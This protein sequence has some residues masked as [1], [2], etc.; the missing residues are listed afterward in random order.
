MSPTFRNGNLLAQ[1]NLTTLSKMLKETSESNDA[2]AASGDAVPTNV[3]TGNWKPQLHFIWDILFDVYFPE[4]ASTAAGDHDLL[5]KSLPTADRASF[6]DFW[7]VVV[8]EGLFN[9]TSTPQRKFWGFEV[10]AKAIKFAGGDDLPVVFTKN[11]MKTWMNQLSGQD[12]YLH[13]AAVQVAKALQSVTKEQPFVGFTLLSQLLGQNGSQNFDKLTRTKTV[14]GIMSGLDAAGVEKYLDYVMKTFTEAHDSES[15]TAENQQ[16]W[17]IDQLAALL[18]NPT[19]PK[20]DK[21]TW[22]ILQHLLLYGFFTVRKANSKSPCQALHSALTSAIVDK[23]TEVCR[24]RFFSC[25]I[26]LTI[27]QRAR[28]S[29]KGKQSL[30]ADESGKLW[31]S[32]ALETMTALEADKKHV[33]PIIDV[34]EEIE[35]ARKEANETLKTLKKSA[36]LQQDVEQGLR[37]LLTFALLKTY[38]DDVKA[39]EILDDVH[40]CAQRLAKPSASSSSKAAEDLPPIDLLVDA[41]IAYLDQASS[42]LKA[43]AG[44]VFGLISSQASESTVEHLIAQLEQIGG[45]DQSDD[46]DEESDDDVMGE[47]DDEEEGEDEDEEED[48]EMVE[49][50]DEDEATA[51]VDPE[52]R[53]RV[54]EALQVS[55]MADAEGEDEAES[56]SDN[57]SDT[58]SIAMDDDQMLALDDK[59]AAI[60]KSQTSAGKQGN[61]ASIVENMHF[62]SRVLDLI[63]IYLRKQQANPLGFS[64]ITPLIRLAQMSGG[65][66]KSVATKA[67]N[68]LLRRFEKSEVVPVET[69]V[70]SVAEILEEI[71]DLARKGQSKDIAKLCSQCS[72]AVAKSLAHAEH[73]DVVTKAYRKSLE[74]YMTRKSSRLPPSFINDFIARQ[75]LQAWPLRDELIRYAQGEAVN[76]FHQEQAFAMLAALAKH[77]SSLSQNVDAAE[78][79]KFVADCQQTI[80]NSLEK[81]AAGE[82]SWG[83]SRV[84]EVIRVALQIAR[85]STTVFKSSDDLAEAWN[86]SRLRELQQKLAETATLKSNPSVFTLLAQFSLL[87][88][89]EAKKAQVAKKQEK[90]DAKKRKREEGSAEGSSKKAVPAVAAKPTKK[91]KVAG[92]KKSEKKVVKKSK[93]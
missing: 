31:L 13:K 91:A 93:A 9:P 8:D 1:S 75:P 5:G 45:G 40:K 27:S 15:G 23:V 89:P 70:E 42:D 80:Y 60:F 57:E 49:E 35:Q 26:D 33:T 78:I 2:A 77:L 6:Q 43:L 84:K 59:L 47:N 7:Q 37:I 17:A 85:H 51:G 10:V 73:G 18:R 52:F 54:A 74:D 83:A 56:G 90:Q 22:T 64:F 19:V 71:H 32:K 4:S 61:K 68:L 65:Q 24:A 20:T 29:D 36:T 28:E 46:E 3:Q 55:G 87:V 30:A 63:E 72:I 44:H 88:D 12:K 41:L 48:E 67:A 66:E 62:K 81:V 69:S 92:E 39:Y 53:K 50:E 58:D 16:I 79:K 82:V 34:D 25:L 76:S 38:D 14:E 11:F 21:T 86:V